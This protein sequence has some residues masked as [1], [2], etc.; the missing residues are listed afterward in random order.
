MLN[1]LPSVNSSLTLVGMV[2]LPDVKLFALCWLVT[3]LGRH[4]NPT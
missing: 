1:L 2:T 4:G 3:D